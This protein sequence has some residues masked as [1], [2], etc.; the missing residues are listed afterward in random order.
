MAVEPQ[1]S[2]LSVGVGQTDQ[3][4]LLPEGQG[5]RPIAGVYASHA[6]VYGP[7]PRHPGKGATGAADG[8]AL[9]PVQQCFCAQAALGAGPQVQLLAWSFSSMGTSMGSGPGTQSPWM[10]GTS[11]GE[12]RCCGSLE[13]AMGEGT[14]YCS[15][16][17]S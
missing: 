9:Q 8:N 2:G 16:G 7:V 4:A 1:D 10:A 6:E 12:V 3:A 5:G 11:E 15:S 13:G 14:D 17:D